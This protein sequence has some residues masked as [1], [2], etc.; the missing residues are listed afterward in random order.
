MKRVC[1]F[2]YEPMRFYQRG[3]TH[4]L[5]ERSWEIGRFRENI[6]EWARLWEFLCGPYPYPE[7]VEHSK[8][9]RQQADAVNGRHL[10]AN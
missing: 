4:R 9:L 3:L 6:D 10:N 7:I 1:E 5:C 8:R 2:C